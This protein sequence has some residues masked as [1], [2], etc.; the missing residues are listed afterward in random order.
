MIRL[1][2]TKQWHI[3]HRIFRTISSGL[4]KGNNHKK[5]ACSPIFLFPCGLTKNSAKQTGSIPLSAKNL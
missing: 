1:I 2:K 5:T 3:E 4:S